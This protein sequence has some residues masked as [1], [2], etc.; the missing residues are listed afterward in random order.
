MSLPAQR[1]ALKKALHVGP[2][3]RHRTPDGVRISAVVNGRQIWF[4]SSEAELAPSPE[5]FGSALL[6]PAMHAGLPLAIEQSVCTTWAG[7]LCNIR[8]TASRWWNYPRLDP[9]LDPVVRHSLPRPATALCFSGGVD[10]FYTLLCGPQPP[11][12]LVAALGYDVKLNDAPR[13]AIVGTSVRAVAA[14]LGLR[15]VFISTNLRRHAA[16]RAIAWECSHGG[17]LAALGHLL[18][19]E[20][21]RLEISSSWS[22]DDD[23][24]WGSRWDVDRFFSSR[25]LTI[26]HI[27]SHLRRTA[28]LHAIAHENIV[29]RH[30]R[31]CWENRNAE[32]NCCQCEKCL[33]TML[34]L[35]ACGQLEHYPQFH[36]GR[37]LLRN[38]DRFPYL[39]NGVISFYELFLEQGL[40]GDYAAA[41]RRLLVRSAE[42]RPPP[43]AR[44]KQ[45][46]SQRLPWLRP[47]PA[48]SAENGWR[49]SWN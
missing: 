33:R 4:E 14:E 6:I 39:S 37:E 34:A 46:F 15:A 44:A 10:S 21:G 35:A 29:R 18:N 9:R 30:L 48:T 13:I 16:F 7:N 23:L 42:R 27:G 11:D 28:K 47:D 49:M 17:A 32:A 45:S 3:V 36:R 5:A 40:T 31:V 22:S 43:L 38:I 20:V 26:D 41:V 8:D 1:T 24:P 25:A 19:N 12:M 2:V